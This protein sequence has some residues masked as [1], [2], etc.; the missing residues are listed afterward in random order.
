MSQGYLA[1]T[2]AM[3]TCVLADR[4]AETAKRY[5]ATALLGLTPLGGAVLIGKSLATISKLGRWFQLSSMLYNSGMT[6]FKAFH[7]L[8]QSLFIFMD[9]VLLGQI[10]IPKANAKF[11]NL[12]NPTD[13]AENLLKRFEK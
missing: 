12:G 3:G 8:C 10:Y 2:A 13:D 11:W 1:A 6:G 9:I 7:Y 4:G 5:A